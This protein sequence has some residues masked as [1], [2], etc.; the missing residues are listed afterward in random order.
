MFNEATKALVSNDCAVDYSDIHEDAIVDIFE[1]NH[2]ILFI[3]KQ[4]DT[5]KVSTLYDPVSFKLHIDIKHRVRDDQ[6]KQEF[7]VYNTTQAKAAI[8]DC[9]NAFLARYGV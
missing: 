4:Y 5:I 8:S 9:F 1:I 2:L 7:I 6:I 3:Y